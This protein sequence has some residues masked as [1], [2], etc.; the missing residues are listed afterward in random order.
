MLELVAPSADWA[1]DMSL[2]DT[3]DTYRAAG[4]EL[5]EIMMG[6]GESDW[7]LRRP[8]V[9]TQVHELLATR[10]LRAHSV[11]AEFRFVEWDLSSKYEG[12]RRLAVDNHAAVLE[13]AARLGAHHVVVHPGIQYL[14]YAPPQ[15]LF[16][17]LRRSLE[18]LAPVA[19]STGVI[20]AL[21]NVD[22]PEIPRIREQMRL[23]L[24]LF[25]PSEVGL[26][27]DTG[28]AALSGEDSGA[29]VRDLH[30]RLVGLHWHDNHGQHDEHR[31]PGLAGIDW[32][33]FFSALRDTGWDLPV[34][35]EARMAAPLPT[36]RL[37]AIA[38]QALQDL[39]PPSLPPELLSA[40]EEGAGS[41]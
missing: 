2:P 10:G 28:H 40:A 17:A 31:F 23:L 6:V 1:L 25:S 24:E 21:E 36:A 39:Q 22:Y 3:L 19:A 8:A 12:M 33:P 16:Q 34:T 27:L 37:L 20:V 30:D 4:L 11:H 18:Q 29:Y 9:L 26:C 41:Q 14:T 13:A 32:E 35:V 5:I 15:V 38:R 7:D